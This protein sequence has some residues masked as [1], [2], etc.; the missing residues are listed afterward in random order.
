[1]VND[2]LPGIVTISQSHSFVA[3][4]LYSQPRIITWDLNVSLAGALS[5]TSAH[6]TVSEERKMTLFGPKT[7]CCMGLRLDLISLLDRKHDTVKADVFLTT[8]RKSGVKSPFFVYPGSL[9]RGGKNK[10]TNKN[11][12]KHADLD[13]CPVETGCGGWRQRK[14]GEANVI[15]LVLF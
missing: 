13:C 2:I 15:K 7:L 5:F 4:L 1:M 9:D 11:K 6:R 8:C 3:C 12:N 10:Q 14:K